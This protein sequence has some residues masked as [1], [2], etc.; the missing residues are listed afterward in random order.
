MTKKPVENLCENCKYKGVY[1]GEDKDNFENWYCRKTI[2]VSSFVPCTR[3]IS[4][5][6][7]E[8]QENDND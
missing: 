5:E 2:L 8:R 1:R 3:I 7:T 4:C 6:M